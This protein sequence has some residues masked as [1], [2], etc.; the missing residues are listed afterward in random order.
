MNWM[1]LVIGLLLLGGVFSGFKNGFFGE[2]ANLLGLILGI[3][4]S[5]RFSWWT[6]DMLADLGLKSQHMH[7]IS[8]IVTFI[9]IVV[10]VHILAQFLNKMLESMALGFVNKLA[11]MAVGIVKSALIISVIVFV[12]NTL[13]EDSKLIKQSVKEESIF[14]EALSEL[15]P[16]IL[17]FLHLEDLQKDENPHRFS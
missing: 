15:V 9:L 1:D 16:T 17:P 14:Y 8:F 3:W 13:D 2:I 5:I 10:L 6:A 4:G 11:G 12:I 7:I